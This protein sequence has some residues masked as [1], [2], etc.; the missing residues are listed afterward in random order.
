MKIPCKKLDYAN[1]LVQFELFFRDIRNLSILSNEDFGFVK[2][3]IK[4]AALSS[5]RTHNNNMHQNLCKEEFLALQNLAK[6][7]GLILQKSSEF[8]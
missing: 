2:A 4:E 8:W 6:N 3:K 5:Y 7:K 1:N